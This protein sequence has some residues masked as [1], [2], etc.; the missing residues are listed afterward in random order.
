MQK[1]IKDQRAQLGISQEKLAEKC[2]FDRTYISLLER[3]KRNPSY[4]SLKKLCIWI[5]G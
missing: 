3:S 5:R 4:L 1:K 2:D